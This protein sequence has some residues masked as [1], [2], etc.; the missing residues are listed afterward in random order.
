MITVDHQIK[1]LIS[2]EQIQERV[3]ECGSYLDSI[4]QG[5]PFVI[6]MIQKGAICFAAD[7]M[8]AIKGPFSVES[9]RC[10]SYG[11]NGIVRGDLMVEGMENLQLQDQHVVV[12]DDICDSG[13]TLEAV[14]QRFQS[15]SVASLRVITLLTRK[16]KTRSFE[17]DFTCFHIEA[18]DFVVGYG[19]DYK[20]YYR[21][22]P[23]LSVVEFC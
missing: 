7:L 15:F 9:I 16:V 4:F 12:V 17:P 18:K 6:V 21:G 19:L 22:L 8:R 20:E 23:D 10:K 11:M 2:R 3:Q 13:V 1:P 14:V 5:E